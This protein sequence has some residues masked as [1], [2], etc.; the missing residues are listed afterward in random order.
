MKHLLL[1]FAL[2]LFCCA[3]CPVTTGDAPAEPKPP[4]PPPAGSSPTVRDSCANFWTLTPAANN[5]REL[6][7]LPAQA[8]QSWQTTDIKGI[9]PG[10]WQSVRADELGFVWLLSAQRTLRFD[11]RKLQEPAVEMPFAPTS[12]ATSKTWRVVSRMPASNHDLTAAV[13]GNKM[14]VS[15]GLTAE[16]GLPTASHPFAEL[17]ELNAQTWRWR[18]ATRLSRERIY[19]ATATFA[20]KIWVLGG[21]V[22]E[23]DGKREATT[24]TEI[25]DPRTGQLAPG[26][27]TQIARPMPVAFSAN[28]RLYIVGNPRGA[29]D[30]PGQ[31]ESLGP[32]ETVWRRE[33]DGPTG[34]GPLA[35]VAHEGKLY[36]LVPKQG[37]AIFDTQTRTW[38]LEKPAA[39]Q[40]SCQM[41]VYRQEIWLLGGRDTASEE[42]T[43]IYNPRTRQWRNG[44]SLP[45]PLSWGAAATVAGKLVVT[46]GAGSYGRDYLYNDRTFVLQER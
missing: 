13:L 6:R 23:P 3:F 4:V 8:P 35:G 27:P 16:W 37:L 36:V 40:R 2:C 42:L 32:G 46:G 29:Y 15:G 5:T 21:D 24:L 43:Q 10:S 14:Y 12:V 20:G 25:Y 28:G 19:C 31:M 22:L 30:Q 9:T 44:P 45:R 38:T 11:P 39:I 17:W 34:M 33:P 26:P 41:A 18:V 1:T 7:V